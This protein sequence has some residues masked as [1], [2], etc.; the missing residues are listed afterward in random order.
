MKKLVLLVFAVVATAAFAGVVE[1][2]KQFTQADFHDSVKPGQG[3]WASNMFTLSV[4]GGS[5]VWLSN[6]VS[7]WYD[8]K[9]LTDLH[10][11]VF[12]MGA[13]QKYGYIFAKDLTSATLA[14]GSYV[15]KIHWSNGNTTEITYTNDSG[16]ETN[17]ATGYFLDYFEDDAEIYL[18]MTTLESDSGEAVDTYQFVK[19]A[20]NDTSMVSRQHNTVDLAGNVR[21]NF[22]I[23]SVSEGLIG[24]EFVAVYDDTAYLHRT[25]TPAGGPLPG[26][27][28]VGL[29][30]MGT[31]F[32]AS[33]M[34]KRS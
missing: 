27:L 31:V 13:D 34:K 32:G 9:P 11:N 20:N 6:Y 23:D 22:G 10:G 29:L 33:R 28:F 24:R 3:W 4:S 26:L 25:V 21:I 15:D 30:S 12:N 18:V 17:S 16:P 5:D 8:P 14:N 1:P 7:S 19:D 2:F